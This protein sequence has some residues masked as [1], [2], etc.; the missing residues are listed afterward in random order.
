MLIPTKRKS[1]IIYDAS[2]AGQPWDIVKFSRER[3]EAMQLKLGVKAL[4][5]YRSNDTSYT[6]REPFSKKVAYRESTH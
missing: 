3:R 2:R 5:A 1:E 4:R 6:K